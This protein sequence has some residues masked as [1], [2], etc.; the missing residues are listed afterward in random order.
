MNT[1]HHSFAAVAIVSIARIAIVL[2]WIVLLYHSPKIMRMAHELFAPLFLEIRIWAMR[3]LMSIGLSIVRLSIV[4]EGI[5][6]R[7]WL[8]VVRKLQKEIDIKGGAR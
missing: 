5:A 7:L 6:Y 4:I 3:L 8:V 1:D 2:G